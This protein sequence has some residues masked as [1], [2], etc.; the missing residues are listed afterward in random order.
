MPQFSPV[1]WVYVFAFLVMMTVNVAIISWW[2][3]MEDCYEVKCVKVKSSGN[4]SG[5][6][7]WG[8][9]FQ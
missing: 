6:F 2:Y 3:K 7:T 8:K 9:K 4:C 5:V 1:S